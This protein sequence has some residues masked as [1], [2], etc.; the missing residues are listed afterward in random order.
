MCGKQ[1]GD[2]PQSYSRTLRSGHAS[3]VSYIDEATQWGQGTMGNNTIKRNNMKDTMGENITNKWRSTPIVL[4][5]WQVGTALTIPTLPP[6][7]AP[8][9]SAA[10]KCFAL[11]LGSG[12]VSVSA[13]ISS[14]GR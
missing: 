4:G 1:I 14:V 3:R 6:Q 13:V 9:P 10:A 12:F 7:A 2:S 5:A 8:S 11:V